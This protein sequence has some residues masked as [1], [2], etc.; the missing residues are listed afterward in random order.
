MQQIK[1]TRIGRVGLKFSENLVQQIHTSLIFR[2]EAR[3]SKNILNFCTISCKCNARPHTSAPTPVLCL[4][5]CF[6]KNRCLVC[7]HFQERI[8]KITFF[9]SHCSF[10]C[11]ILNFEFHLTSSDGFAYFEETDYHALTIPNLKQ[12]TFSRTCTVNN[13]GTYNFTLSI[14]PTY[15]GAT[16]LTWNSPAGN[17]PAPKTFLQ[18]T[19]IG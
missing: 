17:S 19:K 6:F 3:F 5:F 15:T 13:S 16:T 12:T 4:V 2:I 18:F 9:F 14:T 11:I 7:F 1:S 8:Y 10:F